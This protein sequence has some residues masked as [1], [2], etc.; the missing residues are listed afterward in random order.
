MERRRP[1]LR[2][3][4]RHVTGEDARRSTASRYRATMPLGFDG[5]TT[6]IGFPMDPVVVLT[7]KPEMLLEV[8]FDT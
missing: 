1:A 3:C 5:L 4:L 2:A 8:L 6:V 7:L